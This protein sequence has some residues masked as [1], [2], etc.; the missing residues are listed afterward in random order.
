MN[1]KSHNV[2]ISVRKRPLSLVEKTKE[3]DIITVNSNYG[4]TVNE[5][6]SKYDARKYKKIYS[7]KYDKV[8]NENATNNDIFK[9]LLEKN[10][11]DNLLCFAYGLT[12]SGKSYTLLGKNGII[13]M[14]GNKLL[15][16]LDLHKCKIYLSCLELYN[17]K[18]IDL[19]EIKN[20][21]H[22][23]E[24]YNGNLVIANLKKIH[25]TNIK[26]LEDT[27][28][29]SQKNRKSG[30]S[31]KNK[32]SS[33]SHGLFIFQIE[34]NNKIKK[35]TFMDLAGNEKARY[36]DISNIHE[37]SFINQN[38][39][40]LKE[41]IRSMYSKSS[42]VPFRRSK[43]TWM[44]KD[45]FS[46]KSSIIMITTIYP[47]SKLIHD[48]LDSLK[49]SSYF[50]NTN[51]K[52]ISEYLMVEKNINIQRQK[53]YNV[54]KINKFDPIAKKNII[55]LLKKYILSSNKVTDEEITIFNKLY[56]NGDKILLNDC[57]NFLNTKLSLIEELK[58]NLLEILPTKDNINNDNHKII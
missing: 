57:I 33:R 50:K 47:G 24:N 20:N 44:L 8:F 22:M 43:L 18:L 34:I 52:I 13:F 41:C 17:D 10:L 27:L 45:Y 46:S 6:K 12:G 58:K 37:N 25:I 26:L 21:L 5:I 29:I 38:L 42:H 39:F 54:K 16:T 9:S 49:Y 35:I 7:F 51:C 55:N 32:N 19:N 56:N 28:S 23:R 11:N 14:A 30:I 31:F 4:L 2:I 15:N 1:E 53:N 48:T 3:H 40:S 36:S